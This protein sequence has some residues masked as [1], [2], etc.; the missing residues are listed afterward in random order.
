MRRLKWSLR[1]GMRRSEKLLIMAASNFG[2]D[3]IWVR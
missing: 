1:F 2:S 3:N